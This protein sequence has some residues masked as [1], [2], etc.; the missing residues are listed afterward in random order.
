[1]RKSKSVRKGKLVLQRTVLYDAL[2]VNA[3]CLVRSVHFELNRPVGDAQSM[4][5]THCSC[6]GRSTGHIESDQGVPFRTPSTTFHVAVSSLVAP[7]F[8]I[9]G[10][11]LSYVAENYSCLSAR[12]TCSSASLVGKVFVRLSETL[13]QISEAVGATHGEEVGDARRH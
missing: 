4:I 5:M 12:C 8:L 7:A 2:A 10:N 11:L 1:M 3:R 13:F 6:P 9:L